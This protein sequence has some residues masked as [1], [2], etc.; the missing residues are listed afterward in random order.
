MLIQNRIPVCFNLAEQSS[1]WK[2]AGNVIAVSSL[3]PRAALPQEAP[4]TVA[5][6]QTVADE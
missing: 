3:G 4:D 1:L 6:H 5:S 2:L